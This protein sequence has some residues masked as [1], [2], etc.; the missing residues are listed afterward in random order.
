MLPCLVCSGGGVHA[1]LSAASDLRPFAGIPF[2]Q[3]C[4]S[5]PLPQDH[6]WDNLVRCEHLSIPLSL[7][8]LFVYPLP[9][10]EEAYIQVSTLLP[11]E[12]TG[13]KIAPPPPQ[14]IYNPSYVIAGSNTQSSIHFHF[15]R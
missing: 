6:R 4:T 15:C 10:D 12:T 11:M 3:V 9:P 2:P 14:S 7:F 13:G 8:G 5:S 1:S